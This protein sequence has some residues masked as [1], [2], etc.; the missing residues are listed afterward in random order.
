MEIEEKLRVWL[1]KTGY[2]LE[3]FVHKELR[4]RKFICEK[5]QMYSDIETG[6]SREIDLTA[7]KIGASGGGCYELQF[8]IECKKS[9]KPLVVLCD[10]NELIERSNLFFGKEVL[11][12]FR[13]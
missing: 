8:V 7:N 11:D 6:V 2:P 9:D 4:S 13:V 10:G 5:S 12:D 3:L 1:E